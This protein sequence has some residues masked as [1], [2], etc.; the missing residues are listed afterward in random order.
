M[1]NTKPTGQEIDQKPDLGHNVEYV[2]Y[3][4]DIDT[5]FRTNDLG[6]KVFDYHRMTVGKLIK[7][8]I[9]VEPRRADALNKQ[10]HS[11]A[12]YLFKQSDVDE[13]GVPE[14]IKRSRVSIDVFHETG[15]EWKDEFTYSKK[16]N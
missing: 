2:E 6:A 7:S 12:A 4:L 14:M 15:T 1:A 16:I 11:R 10:A 13:K 9:R 3:K 5:K 8:K